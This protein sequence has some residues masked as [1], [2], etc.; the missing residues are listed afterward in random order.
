MPKL[1]SRESL[2]GKLWRADGFVSTAVFET[3]DFLKR[4]HS[5]YVSFLERFRIRGVKRVFIDLL[6][7]GVTF[8]VIF[9]T[10]VLQGLSLPFLIRWLGVTEDD[11]PSATPEGVPDEPQHIAETS[12]LV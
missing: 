2:S 4:R 8:G 6:D 7:D 10:L 1:P 3:W 11:G 9:S 5:A 12:P